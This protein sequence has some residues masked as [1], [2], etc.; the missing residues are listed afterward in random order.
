M[1][2][3]SDQALR[4]RVPMAHSTCAALRY[5]RVRICGPGE[6][7]LWR[8]GLWPGCELAAAGDT[9]N[10]WSAPLLV[11]LLLTWP[12]VPEDSVR[13]LPLECSRREGV[14]GAVATLLG[15]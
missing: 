5:M 9:D 1:Q 15:V 13:A 4:C 3:V 6:N 8:G 11:P 12:L 2:A 10:Q 7:M 14:S